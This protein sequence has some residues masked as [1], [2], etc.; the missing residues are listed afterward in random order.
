MTFTGGLDCTQK[1]S[2]MNFG[3]SVL[4]L[5]WFVL[6][7]S[8]LQPAIQFGLKLFDDWVGYSKDNFGFHINTIQNMLPFICFC[9]RGTK[10]LSQRHDY[11]HV[12][13]LVGCCNNQLKNRYFLPCIWLKAHL[14]G[15]VL[16]DHDR[17]KC[18]Y[19]LNISVQL[20]GWITN[21]IPELER[22]QRSISA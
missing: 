16:L 18:N 19:T 11:Q 9:E 15:S 8:C 1:A 10:D 3:K 5:L 13:C 12:D 4:Q 2:A 20:E 6:G 21:N 22:R 14:I 17:E 7:T